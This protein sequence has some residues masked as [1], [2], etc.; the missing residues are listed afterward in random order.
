VRTE[1]ENNT[2]EHEPRVLT[3]EGEDSLAL[4]GSAWRRR[5][6]DGVDWWLRVDDSGIYRVATKSDLDDEPRPIRRRAT[7]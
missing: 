5:S 7:C 3:T 6:A 1:W 2:V 4:S